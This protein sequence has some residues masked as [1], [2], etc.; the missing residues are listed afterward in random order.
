MFLAWLLGSCR[1]RRSGDQVRSAKRGVV[2]K[3]HDPVVG[4]PGGAHNADNADRTVDL[5]TG[6]HQTA[7]VEFVAF[8][9]VTDRDDLSV[10]ELAIFLERAGSSLLLLFEV[11]SDVA[12]LLLK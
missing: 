5:V 2:D 12:Q 4:H 1:S 9:L 8:I 6:R 3:G 7:Q 11:K 10:R